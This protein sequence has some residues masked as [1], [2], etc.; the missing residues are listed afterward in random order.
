MLVLCS[1]CKHVRFLEC[2][3]G[4]CGHSCKLNPIPKH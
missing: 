2:G 3:M 4:C 1:K